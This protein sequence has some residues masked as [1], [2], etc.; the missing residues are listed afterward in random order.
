MSAAGA[1]VTVG[2]TSYIY[3]RG[4][5]RGQSQGSRNNQSGI[6][7]AQF[8]RDRFVAQMGA[9]TGG[10]LLTREMVVADVTGDAHRVTG[11]ARTTYRERTIG[12]GPKQ[13]Q[14]IPVE[15]PT[16][17]ASVLDFASGP[18]APLCAQCRWPHIPL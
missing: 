1:L 8:V 6:G 13:G 7:R 11:S 16:H 17:I 5:R 15:T 9:H 4:S 10:F 14:R 3:Y 2:D 12:S 18:V